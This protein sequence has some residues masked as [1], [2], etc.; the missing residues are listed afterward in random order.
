MKHNLG[1]IVRVNHILDAIEN[2]ELILH[3][4]T[5]EDF[6]NNLEK[7]LSVER[8]LEIISEATKNISEDVF[9]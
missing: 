8:L 4:V 7:S 3:N 1:D 5:I 2:I 9:V 6:K